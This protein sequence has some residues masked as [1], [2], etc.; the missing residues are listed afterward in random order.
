MRGPEN[1]GGD[2]TRF[3]VTELSTTRAASKLLKYGGHGGASRLEYFRD[4]DLTTGVIGLFGCTSVIV[5]STEAVW[6]SHWWEDP[7][8]M[9]Q[10]FVDFRDQMLIPL[11]EGYR[12]RIQGLGGLTSPGQPFE[13]LNGPKAFIV[14][15]RQDD[16]QSIFEYAGKINIVEVKLRALMPGISITRYEYRRNKGRATSSRSPL[17]KVLIQYSATE[18]NN[19]RKYRIWVEAQEA[20]EESWPAADVN[21]YRSSST[22]TSSDYSTSRRGSIITTSDT[23][24]R[25]STITTSDTSRRS[26][27]ISSSDTSR[28][29]STVS[30]SSYSTSTAISTSASSSPL[31]VETTLSTPSTSSSVAPTSTMSSSQTISTIIP[32]GAAPCPSLGDFNTLP[33][34]DGEDESIA[35]MGENPVAGGDGFAYNLL[36]ACDTA[37]VT[38][39]LTWSDNTILV[40]T[41]GL[42]SDHSNEF[43]TPG[44]REPCVFWSVAA[45]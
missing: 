17:G 26:S 2:V 19:W 29:S 31:E 27:T 21:T 43:D 7:I 30:S 14:S 24:R 25:G 4:Q 18:P 45:A 12:D 33:C 37:P 35:V 36:S 16:G 44:N 38:V 10:S 34:P 20:L 6:V 28:R 11:V 40:K 39:T 42:P 23:S 41:L 13:S 8:F 15:V 32:A 5:V 3:F 9:I 22:I 1:Y